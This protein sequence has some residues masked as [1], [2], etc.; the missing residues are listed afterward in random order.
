LVDALLPSLEIPHPR[1]EAGRVQNAAL[2]AI[3]IWQLVASF[4]GKTRLGCPLPVCFLVAPL[5][6]HQSTLEAAKRTQL[7]LRTFASKLKK[8]ELLSI[9]GRM[10]RMRALSLRSLALSTSCGLTAISVDTAMVFA[11]SREKVR[12]TPARVAPIL[13]QSLKLGEWFSQV[14]L[15][16]AAAILRVSF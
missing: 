15:A 7:N 1:G 9:H 10:L 16:E 8:E 12:G 4:S 13:R 14:T 5:L 3:L 6:L 2:C 11:S